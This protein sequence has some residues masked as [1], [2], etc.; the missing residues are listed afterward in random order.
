MGGATDQVRAWNPAVPG[1]AEVLHAHWDDHAY[2]P[3]T[4]ET[5]T[6]LVVDDGLIGYGLDRHEHAAVRSGVTVLPPHVVHDGRSVTAEG[7]T[8]RVV[9]VDESVLEESLIGGAVDAPLISDGALR[10]QISL[11]DRALTSGETLEAESRLALVGDRVAWHLRGRPEHRTERAPHAPAQVARRAREIIDADPVD[12]PGVGEI[13]ARLQ[14]SAPY[15]IRSFTREFALP[16]HRYLLGRRL[17]LARRQLLAGRPVAEVAVATGFHDQAHLTRH[18]RRML[19][20]TPGR[21]QRT[22]RP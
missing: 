5:W 10:R 21:Y 19:R 3:H 17:E 2:P 22:S 6:L 8:K 18:F 20:T 15:L 7:F 13:A 12:A 14:V 1:V 4:H 9:Y 11:L 16:P